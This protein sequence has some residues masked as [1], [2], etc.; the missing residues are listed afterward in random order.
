[1]VAFATRDFRS[2]TVM[3]IC[4]TKPV[5]YKNL[6]QILNHLKT[7]E[8]NHSLNNYTL[9]KPFPETLL[10]LC[11]LCVCCFN[12]VFSG[13]NPVTSIPRHYMVLQLSIIKFAM[14]TALCSTKSIISDN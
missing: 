12:F 9:S 14:Y 6:F 4:K 10:I 11:V 13:P 7:I 5:R 3:W 2:R 8:P 1:M